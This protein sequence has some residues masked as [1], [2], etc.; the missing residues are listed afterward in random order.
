MLGFNRLWVLHNIHIQT[1]LVT[2]NVWD[3]DNVINQ[4]VS[5]INKNLNSYRTGSIPCFRSTDADYLES[6]ANYV[7]SLGITT[8]A[9]GVGQADIDEL[10]VSELC[11]N[12]R[13]ICFQN[14][15]NDDMLRLRLNQ[16]SMNFFWWLL[17]HF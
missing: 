3:M 13:V 16:Y 5:W 6:S 4:W 2:L 17:K 10:R 9:V 11:S 15:F 1:Y 8:F 7:R 12:N 14:R